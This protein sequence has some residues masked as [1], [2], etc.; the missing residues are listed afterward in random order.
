MG[1]FKQEFRS[2]FYVKDY[3]ENIRFYGE[4]LELKSNYS[5]NY[6]QND[7]GIKYIVAGGMLEIISRHPPLEQGK[8]TIMIE[9][10]DVDACYASLRKK[11]WLHF[12]EEIADRPYGI[13][14]FR[15]MDPNGND[16]VIFSYI[17]NLKNRGLYGEKE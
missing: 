1:Y 4:G 8:G 14:V 12:I 10:E 7:R 17:E 15:L 2:V 9:A 13:R 11:D 5:W 6:A 3:E 16:V